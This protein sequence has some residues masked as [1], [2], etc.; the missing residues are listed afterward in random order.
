[1]NKLV[2]IDAGHGG[3]DSGAVG[4][5]IK[6]K[7]V[8]LKVVKRIGRL[9]G[10]RGISIMYTRI[11]DIYVG[12]KERCQ[13]AN[14]LNA[15]L[16]VSVHIN[17]AASEQASGT[18]TLCYNK[19]RLA[20]FIQKHLLSKLK[21]KDRGIKE[22]KDLAVLNGTLMTAV[23]CEL[24]FLSNKAE[25]EFIKTE[26]FIDLAAEAIVCGICE[27]FRMEETQ[28]NKNTED[29]EMKKNIDVIING[30]K[31]C[32]GGYFADGKNLFTADFIRQ[33]G[34]R[35]TYNPETKEVSFKGKVCADSVK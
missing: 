5:G 30:E 4:N 23:L 8:V 2:C 33:L 32:T 6:E 3:Y 27:Y 29:S 12:L 35:V 15:D 19:N 24:A 26:K 18:E 17:S 10:D 22:R 13:I 16:F 25:A 31:G 20:E 7:D 1:M 9:L 11:S 14:S 28:K 21:L 34:F